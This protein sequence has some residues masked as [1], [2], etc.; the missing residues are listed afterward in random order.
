MSS[1]DFHQRRTSQWTLGKNF[2]TFGPIG[3]ALA[4]KDEVPDPN[5][6]GI[7]CR[8]GNELLQDSNTSEMVCRV[9]DLVSYLSSVMTLEPG[10][11]IATGTPAGVGFTRKPPRFLRHGDTV[12]VE[13]DPASAC[14][15]IRCGRRL[16]EQHVRRAVLHTLM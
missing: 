10:D 12:R 8:I 14:W 1:R 4:T 15:R 13:I 9:T 11:V 2:D 6:L 3:P 16:Q 7:R 5:A